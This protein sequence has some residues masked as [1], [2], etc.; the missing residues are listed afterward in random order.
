MNTKLPLATLAAFGLV[1]CAT[2]PDDAPEAFHSAE[3]SVEILDENNVEAVFP[4][5]ASRIQD[6]F[7]QAL[8]DLDRSEDPSTNI[9]REYAALQ[10]A[11]VKREADEL[12]RLSNEVFAWDQ[13]ETR[14][15]DA[16]ALLDRS[17]V[18]N[19]FAKL[20]GTE[21]S[22]PIAYYEF[23]DAKEPIFIS[24]KEVEA[25]VSV[26]RKDPQFK[27]ILTGYTDHYGPVL[28]NHKL[29]LSRAE[30]VAHTLHEK[31]VS[32]SQLIYR[33]KG[34]S[35]AFAQDSA[36]EKKVLDRRVDATLML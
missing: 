24:D 14:F 15:R 17:T 10:A 9:S 22:S 4:Q 27:V 13:S 7:D 11:T 16:L 3:R 34:E 30:Q 12:I 8:D 32:T 26:L 19:R 20:K 2:V 25:L 23:D 33:S 29:G 35:E 31:G 5:T 6:R 21:I 18:P 1:A 28:Y 36:L